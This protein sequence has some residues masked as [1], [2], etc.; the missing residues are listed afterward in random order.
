MEKIESE[1]FKEKYLYF[2][3]KNI[4]KYLSNVVDQQIFP[5]M[6]DND[7]FLMKIY[8]DNSRILYSNHI[9][10]KI[11]KSI[12]SKYVS[13]LK[14][15]RIYVDIIRLNYS[16]KFINTF[17]E[18]IKNISNIHLINTKNIDFIEENEL[19]YF[20]YSQ[21]KNKNIFSDK[22][23]NS[24]EYFKYLLHQDIHNSIIHPI[25]I[26]IMLSRV[27]ESDNLNIIQFRDIRQI[28]YN[29]NKNK[30]E[31]FYLINKFFTLSNN[32]K[33]FSPK[34]YAIKPFILIKCTFVIKNNNLSIYITF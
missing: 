9:K 24:N 6:S 10:I 20:N 30:I 28:Y 2:E 12:I 15:D 21:I 3:K 8:M 25:L 32:E 11:N 29:C 4:G 33:D 18:N 13:E 14:N 26:S 19:D 7:I 22:L 16:R 1:I 27:K 31:M 5:N 23:L 17:G 34:E